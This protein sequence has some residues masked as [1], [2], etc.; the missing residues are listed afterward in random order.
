[1][2]TIYPQQ[3]TNQLLRERELDDEILSQICAGS[4]MQHILRQLR[5]KIFLGGIVFE[6]GVG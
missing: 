6:D 5:Y 4:R 1:M 3:Q 2:K